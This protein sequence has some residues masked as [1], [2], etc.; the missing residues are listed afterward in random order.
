MYFAAVALLDIDFVSIPCHSFSFTKKERSWVFFVLHVSENRAI[1][2][3]ESLSQLL[4]QGEKKKKNVLG[5]FSYY[6][7]QR[8]ALSDSWSVP[9]VGLGVKVATFDRLVLLTYCR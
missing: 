3:L 2:Q 5:Y 7:S 6:T 1:R 9:V 4:I 8:I